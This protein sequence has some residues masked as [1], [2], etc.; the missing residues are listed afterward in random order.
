M[1]EIGGG[2]LQQWSDLGDLASQS[3]DWDTAIQAYKMAL[4]LHPRP[5][6]EMQIC[7]NCALAIWFRAGFV[8]KISGATTDQEYEEVC[9]ARALYRRMLTLYETNLNGRNESLGVEVGKLYQYA[10]DNLVDSRE[11]CM[12]GLLPDGML[13]PRVGDPPTSFHLE[14]WFGKQGPFE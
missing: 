11:F 6:L 10:K 8:D 14:E 5:E 4:T 9:A 3:R 2:S 1:N 13:F 12:V 7:W